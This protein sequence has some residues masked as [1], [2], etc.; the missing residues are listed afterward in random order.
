MKKEFFE[1]KNIRLKDF[2]YSSCGEYFITICTKDR[3]NLFWEKEYE[4][5]SFSWEFVGEN[6]V[7]PKNLPLSY[8]GKIVFSQIKKWNSTYESVNISSFIIM[9][10][11]IHLIVCINSNIGRTQFSPTETNNSIFSINTKKPVTIMQMVK[12][13]KGAVTK[14]LGFSLWQ[15][16]FM[17]HIIRDENDFIIRTEYIMKNPFF[18]EKDPLYIQEK[19]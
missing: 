4:L 15:R 17:E 2:D 19:P 11:H 13:F 14:I 1:R 3:K 18:L 8:F 10:N 7:L 12:Q 5:S 9:P 16:S 6:C